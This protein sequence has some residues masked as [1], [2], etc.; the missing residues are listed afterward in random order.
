MKPTFTEEHLNV[1]SLQHGVTYGVTGNKCGWAVQ[2]ET[3]AP[4]WDKHGVFG[5]Q[6][7]GSIGK[8]LQCEHET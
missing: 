3:K 1:W 4:Y 2:K 8:D 7:S 6:G 5:G